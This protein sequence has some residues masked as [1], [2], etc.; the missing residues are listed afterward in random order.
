MNKKMIQSAVAMV[1]T[2]LILA[3]CKGEKGDPGD[4]LKGDLKGS[5]QLIEEDGSYRLPNTHVDYKKV[6]VNIEGIGNSGI[7]NDRNFFFSQL[8]GGNYKISA[9][10]EGYGTA[11]AES[12]KHYGGGNAPNIGPQFTLIK[13]SSTEITSLSRINESDTAFY[14]FSIT[15][16]YKEGITKPSNVIMLLACTK[17]DLSINNYEKIEL[18]N[19]YYSTEYNTEHYDKNYFTSSGYLSKQNLEGG[20][21]VQ[22]QKILL[23]KYKGKSLYFRAYSARGNDFPSY[24]FENNIPNPANDVS[25]NIVKL[26]IE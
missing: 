10:C 14:V 26:T 15:G 5:V 1:C 18:Y 22:I 23:K 25:S 12:F 6:S 13:K 19:R 3:A 2:A 20:G 11:L 16:K 4:A 21:T 17:S 8:P 7:D 24:Y 9:S